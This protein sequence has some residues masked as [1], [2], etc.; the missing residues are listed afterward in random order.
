MFRGLFGAG[1][2]GVFRRQHDIIVCMT[3]ANSVFIG[4]GHSHVWRA[5]KDFIADAL[6][7]PWDEF[8]R[9]P[10]AGISTTARLK[11]MLDNAGF[12][13][14]VMTGEDERGAGT[15]HARDNVIHELGLFQGK[16]GF[17][18]AIILLEEGCARFSNLEGLTYIS[19]PKGKIDASFEEIRKVLR[20]EE[21]PKAP[22]PGTLGD[23][24]ENS[25]NFHDGAYWRNRDG[26]E[27]GPFCPACWDHDRKLVRG[28][29]NCV[30]AGEVQ[31]FCGYHKPNYLYNVPENL[32]KDIPLD[33]HRP[34][35]VGYSSQPSGGSGGWMR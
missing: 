31:F 27:E 21:F 19:F 28:R 8:N 23:G 13:F 14:L 20:R 10:V 34:R 29:V 11:Q 5:L 22:H 3:P 7:L 24:R 12:A 1:C 35:T 6:A 2:V 32:V 16:L 15:T 4:H 26:G 17:E 33:S 9:E 18:R 30:E 25:P